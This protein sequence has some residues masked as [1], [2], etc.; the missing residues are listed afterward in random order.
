MNVLQKVTKKYLKMKIEEIRQSFK[1]REQSSIP[2]RDAVE[3]FFIA[4]NMVI[5]IQMFNEMKVMQRKKKTII[6]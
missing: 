2:G 4:K 3:A 5:A 6:R 1:Q